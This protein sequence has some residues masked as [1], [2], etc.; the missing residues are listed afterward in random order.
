MANFRIVAAVL[1]SFAALLPAQEK[2]ASTDAAKPDGAKAVEAT[3]PGRGPT[4]GVV[5]LDKARDQYPKAIA[6]REKLQKLSQSFQEQLQA[7]SK[8]IEEIRAAQSLLTEGT[9]EWE[10]KQAERGV[11]M[12]QQKIF[13]D[14]F[15]SQFDRARAKFDLMIYQDFEV[16]IA[17]VAK[18]RGVQIVLRM[19]EAPDADKGKDA[20]NVQQARLYSYNRRNV[21]FA[22]DEVDLTPALIKYLQVPLDTSK[23]AAPKP[24]A[25]AAK[26]AGNGQ[27]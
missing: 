22:A 21:W 19:H 17:Q 1:T 13:A 2:H 3:A 6:E 23:A 14:L 26:A 18:D 12:Q 25:P 9:D 5:D 16:A 11:V 4:I 10:A 15:Q 20:G 24:E 8:R 7:L 27:K